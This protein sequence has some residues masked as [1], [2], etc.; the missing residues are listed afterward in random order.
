[1]SFLDKLLGREKKA[2][3]DATGD[4]SMASEGMQQEQEAMASHP[5]EQAQEVAQE[6]PEQASEHHAERPDGA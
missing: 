4:S 3:G 1:M 6:A 2:A 5:A